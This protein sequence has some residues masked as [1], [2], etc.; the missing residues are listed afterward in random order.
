MENAQEILVIIL[1]VFLALFL[2]LN[3]VFLIIA[4]KIA[5][6]VKRVSQKAENLADKAEAFGEFVQHAATP[7]IIGRL[8]SNVSDALFNRSGKSK[9]K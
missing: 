2:I 4:I 9:R 5:L 7:M 3:S 6:T 1:S 8:F